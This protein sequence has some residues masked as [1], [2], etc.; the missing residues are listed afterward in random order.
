MSSIRRILIPACLA[1]GLIACAGASSNHA[2][3]LHAS[4]MTVEVGCASCIYEME[5]VMWC[6]PA[7]R[8]DGKT[9]LVDFEDFDAH[10][11]G[12]CDGTKT[13]TVTGAIEGDHFHATSF[14]LT[15]HEGKH[16]HE[17]EHGEEDEHNG[18][19]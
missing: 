9:Y 18:D 4:A 6:E 14:E 2:S 12:L 15:G 8:I 11:A 7:A 17:A 3:D 10:G 13:A 16:G 5:G 19:H 1:L